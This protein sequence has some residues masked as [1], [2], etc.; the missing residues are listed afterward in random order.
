MDDIPRTKW[1]RLLEALPG[2]VAWFFIL[3]PFV[4]AYWFPRAV[5][6][7]IAMYVILWFLR[8]MKSSGFL[9]HSYLKK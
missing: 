1:Y 7:F 6:V 9:V 5:A 8:A 4:L 2:S 3:G